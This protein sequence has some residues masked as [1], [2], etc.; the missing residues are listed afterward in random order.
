M[1]YKELI[2]KD[3]AMKSHNLELKKR[4]SVF[5]ELIFQKSGNDFLNEQVLNR[6]LWTATEDNDF[7]QR[8]KYLGQPYWSKKAVVQYQKQNTGRKKKNFKDLRH[9]HSFPKV[10]IRNKILSLP[11]KNSEE[12][13]KI[14]DEYAHV[15]IITKDEDKK[16]RDAG[17]NRN[18]PEDFSLNKDITSRYSQT[19]IEILNISDCDLKVIKT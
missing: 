7:G 3:S 9:D 1:M 19:D 11:K 14:L 4:I 13:F 6:F 16:L 2:L 5:L 8:V 12:I 10:L 15:V 18:M 17:F